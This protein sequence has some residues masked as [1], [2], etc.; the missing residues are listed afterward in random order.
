MP[1][2]FSVELSEGK[3]SPNRVYTGT[4][5]S[6]HLPEAAN[7]RQPTLA[8]RF[9]NLGIVNHDDIDIDDDLDTSSVREDLDSTASGQLAVEMRSRLPSEP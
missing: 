9:A 1:N 4:T 3:S 2:S 7:S 6:V 8:E 5:E